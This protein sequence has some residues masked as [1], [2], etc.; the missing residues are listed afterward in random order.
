MT[1][2]VVTV[3]P[4]LFTEPS[5][6]FAAELYTKPD[7]GYCYDRLLRRA[8]A[9]LGRGGMASGLKFDFLVCCPCVIGTATSSGE[10]S[11]R[12][13]ET[14]FWC[15][16]EPSLPIVVFGHLWNLAASRSLLCSSKPP[17]GFFFSA[18]CNEVKY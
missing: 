18:G 5:R 7:P 4:R 9:P 12:L 13:I 8:L 17:I 15:E 11:L 14:G 6:I 2:A 16:W 10:N 3:A 1:I